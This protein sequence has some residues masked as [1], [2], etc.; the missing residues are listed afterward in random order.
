MVENFVSNAHEVMTTFVV[1][2][3]SKAWCRVFSAIS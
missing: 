2:L 1:L 3:C